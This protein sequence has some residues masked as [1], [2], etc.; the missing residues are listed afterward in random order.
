MKT[1]EQAL[2]DAIADIERD[3]QDYFDDSDEE[4]RKQILLL[5]A[6]FRIQLGVLQSGVNPKAIM[7][8]LIG[9]R[10]NEEAVGEMQKTLN[11]MLY[12]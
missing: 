2:K 1:Q 6:D 9:V 8:G 11:D 3:A 5:L 12:K 7:T 10:I 4:T